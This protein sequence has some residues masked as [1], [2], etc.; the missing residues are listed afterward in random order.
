[1]RTIIRMSIAALL[2]AACLNSCSLDLKPDFT[3]P[4]Y[5]YKTEEDVESA[6]YG[7]Y[8]ALMGRYNRLYNGPIYTYLSISDEF[9]YRSYQPAQDVRIYS[10]DASEIEIQKMWVGLYQCISRAN[11]LIHYAGQSAPDTDEVKAMLGEA[12]FLRGYCYFLLVTNFGSIPMPLEPTLS[13]D[14]RFFLEQTSIE[15]VYAQIIKD[16]KEA[17]EAVYEI[18]ELQTNERISKTG[19]QAMLARVYMSMAGKPLEETER[20]A[21][22]A[23]YCEK[24]IKSGKHEL[25]P[26][27]QQ[28]FINHI[29][30][31]SEPKE[32]LW[33]IAAFG[34]NLDGTTQ[35][36]MLGIEN[37]ISC[38]NET[39]GYSGG[40]IRISKKL[41]DSFM[42]DSDLRRDWCV[43]SYY[44]KTVP[45]TLNV[46]KTEWGADKIRE[47]NCGKWRREYETGT[48]AKSFNATNFPA[49]RYSDVLLMRAE[50]LNA[51]RK[52]PNYEAYQLV[53]Q[54]RR[55]AAG[56]PVETP[57]ASV[58]L[59]E[60]MDEAAFLA[61]IKTERMAELCFEG[62]R[63]TDLVRWGELV[64]NVKAMGKDLGTYFPNN[65]YKLVGE[66]ISDRNVLF[67]IPVSEYS[68]NKNIV[69]NVGW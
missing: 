44:Y 7:C 56:L 35:A 42:G 60:T 58:D 26:D 25:N 59:P 17:E 63:K 5:S 8:N 27:Y 62:M 6:L 39:V 50:A 41:W 46:E 22:A 49:L 2:G 11:Y 21:D 64:E 19:V 33:E 1:M 16:M 61:V 40:A 37:G 38:I 29:T 10:F 47:R 31:V 57:D 51:Q 68:M 53:D 24:V 48:K 3:T 43:A 13:P 20:Y 65:S 54:V 9:Y 55:R 45:N 32:C 4:E 36:G 67:P 30:G 52:G 28:I 66:N 14:S 69:Q 23:D 18:D 12:K 15:G 34:N